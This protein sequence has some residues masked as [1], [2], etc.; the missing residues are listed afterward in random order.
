MK[1]AVALLSSSSL[2]LMDR[3]R[4]ALSPLACKASVLLSTPAALSF[5]WLVWVGGFEPPP[6]VPRTRMLLPLHHTQNE[7]CDEPGRTRTFDPLLKR[8][9]PLSILATGSLMPI[10]SGRRDSNSQPQVWLTCALACLSY[11]R[12]INCGM[13]NAHLKKDALIF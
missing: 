10:W 9:V 8:Q 1:K 5:D 4:L 7:N 12:P 2:L 11:S 6:R 13:R 3:L